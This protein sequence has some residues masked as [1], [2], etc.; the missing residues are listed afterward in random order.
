[1][2]RGTFSHSID[3]KGRLAVP[4][5][6][7]EQLASLEDQVVV[8]TKCL[9][10]RFRCLDLYPESEW[11]RLEARIRAMPPFDPRTVDFKR[12][13]IHPAQDQALDAQG[14]ILVP[15]ELRA[16]AGLDKEAQFT[17]D[18]QKFQLWDLGEWQR[19]S[20]ALEKAK[21]DPGFFSDFAL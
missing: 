15:A 2:F 16:H 20:E 17:G 12:L 21:Q 5:R 11:A 7:R 3:E 13:Y 19:A 9:D 8:I 18:L 1:M 14:R 4:R 10:P 6:F